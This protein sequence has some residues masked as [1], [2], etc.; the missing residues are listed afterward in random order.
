MPVRS[1]ASSNGGTMA[2]GGRRTWGMTYGPRL[3]EP[4]TPGGRGEQGELTQVVHV[5][6]DNTESSAR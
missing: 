2:G 3:E 4:I 5:V 6:G 1:A